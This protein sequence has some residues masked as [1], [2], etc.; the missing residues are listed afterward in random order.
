MTAPSRMRRAAC[1]TVQW[2]RGKGLGYSPAV[3]GTVYAGGRVHAFDGTPPA[4][5][6]AIRDGRVAGTGPRDA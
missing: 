1:R 5:A 2:P 6:I 4:D 3:P